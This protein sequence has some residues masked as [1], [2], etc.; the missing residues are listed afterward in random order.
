LNLEKL[1]RNDR[2][3]AVVGLLAFIDS[4][5]PWYSVSVKS[6]GVDG[7]GAYSASGSG[8]A[9]REGFG[10]WFPLLLLL[11][12]GVLAV[13]PAFEQKV[14]LP[15]GDAAL[16]IVGAVAAVLILLRWLTYPSVPS[17]GLYG[18]VSAG[19]SFG[20]YIG[21]VLAIVTAVIGYL[22]FT[23]S[24]GSLNNLGAAF[25]KQPSAPVGQYPPQQG[26]YPPPVD[27]GQPQQAPYQPPY[28]P[29][30][31]PYQPPQGQY[32]PPQDPQ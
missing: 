28:Q 19:A 27:Y 16:A 25:S 10:A 22:G 18:S 7:L 6:N 14:A 4:F 5:L 32:Q 1:G 15:G 13:L 9:W 17:D 2:I 30:Q 21:L 11:A 8:N 29:P 23:A 3:L 24:G 20:T 26:G 12:V 31:A